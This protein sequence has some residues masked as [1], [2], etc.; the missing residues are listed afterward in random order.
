M[1]THGPKVA[2]HHRGVSAGGALLQHVLQP[3][4]V[5][6]VRHQQKGAAGRTLSGHAHIQLAVAAAHLPARTA[7]VVFTVVVLVLQA[8]RAR[9]HGIT[10][11]GRRSRR[12]GKRCPQA[13]RRGRACDR[14]Q[15][16]RARRGMQVLGPAAAPGGSG[17]CARPPS[18]AAFGARASSGRPACTARTGTPRGLVAVGAGGPW[19]R[20]SGWAFFPIAPCKMGDAWIRNN[21]TPRRVLRAASKGTRPQHGTV[22]HASFSVLER[23]RPP[24]THVVPSQSARQRDSGGDWAASTTH[25]NGTPL[26]CMNLGRQAIPSWREAPGN[27]GMYIE[28]SSK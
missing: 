19:P 9:V 15:W 4:K 24:R 28:H 27:R 23:R 3:L 17:A 6:L 12:R 5:D 16:D 25:A 10:R 2:L 18:S 14:V 7:R 21:A 20:A 22:L 11:V 8:D 13:A 1:L 26:P